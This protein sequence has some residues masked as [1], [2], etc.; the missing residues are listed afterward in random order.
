MKPLHS[1]Q[2]CAGFVPECA[3]R[4]P[5]CSATPS[6][7]SS[8][9]PR[10]LRLIGGAIGGSAVAFTLMACYGAPCSSGSCD[11]YPEEDASSGDATRDI[12]APD[13]SVGPRDAGSDAVVGSESDASQDASDDV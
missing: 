6:R 13:V 9:L 5:N 11:G 8:G 3:P 12:T 7:S 10:S 2:Q 1:C 4:C